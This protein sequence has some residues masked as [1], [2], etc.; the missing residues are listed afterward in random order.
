MT[1]LTYEASQTQGLQIPCAADQPTQ[2]F[3]FSLVNQPF[4]DVMKASWQ[5]AQSRRARA[6]TAAKRA[7]AAPAP[8]TTEE[9][10]VEL[11]FVLGVG[12]G[13]G[14]GLGTGLRV[15]SE[16]VLIAL[17]PAVSVQ[18]PPV[19]MASAEPTLMVVVEVAFVFTA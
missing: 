12:V 5:Q 19:G 4:P 7:K 3:V 2:R 16:V 8:A 1:S 18:A 17:I 14:V 15:Q 10:D 9:A 6:A 13:L 11:L